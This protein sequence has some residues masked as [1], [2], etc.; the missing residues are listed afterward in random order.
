MTSAKDLNVLQRYL[1]IMRVTSVNALVAANDGIRANE[2]NEVQAHFQILPIEPRRLR[3]FNGQMIKRTF[4]ANLNRLVTYL[5]RAKVF[6]ALRVIQLRVRHPE[7]FHRSVHPRLRIRLIASNRMVSAIHRARTAVKIVRVNE[8]RGAKL[9][10]TE[11]Q[12]GRG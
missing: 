4:I 10:A 11:G 1:K 7:A 9:M 5:R 6:M 2:G 8:R 3:I 12:R